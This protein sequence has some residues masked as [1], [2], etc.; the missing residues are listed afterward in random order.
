MAGSGPPPNPLSRKQSGQQAHTWTDLPANGHDG[1]TPE[2]P[3]PD[4]TDREATLWDALWR[5]PQAAVW[6]RLSW[7]VDVAIYVRVLTMAEAGDLKAIT[8][9]RLRSVELGLTPTGMLKNRWRIKADD[10]AEKR[11][12]KAPKRKPRRLKVVDGDAVAGS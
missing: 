7:A 5:T 4:E 2:W 6:S 1:P 3:L 10:V 9:A 12:E 8:E 11:D